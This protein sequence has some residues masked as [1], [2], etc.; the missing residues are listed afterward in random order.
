MAEDRGGAAELEAELI[1]HC[2]ARLAS[3]QR[4]RNYGPPVHPYAA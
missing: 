3:N 4:G 2:R 1:A